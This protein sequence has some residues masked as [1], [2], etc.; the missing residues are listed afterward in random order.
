MTRVDDLAILKNMIGHDFVHGFECIDLTPD[1]P[2]TTVS[3][4]PWVVYPWDKGNVFVEQ[5]AGT[6]GAD[7]RIEVSNTQITSDEVGHSD[8][9]TGAGTGFTGINESGAAFVRINVK[10][11]G[12]GGSI[13]ATGFGRR[14]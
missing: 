6:T 3:V 11:P 7:V 4:G 13:T 1:G 12:T 9:L 5:I 8:S 10:D 14:K 2:I